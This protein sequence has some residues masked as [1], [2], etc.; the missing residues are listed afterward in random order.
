MNKLAEKPLDGRKLFRFSQSLWIGA[1]GLIFFGGGP[2]YSQE[3]ESRSEQRYWVCPDAD[4]SECY[5][6]VERIFD[7][8]Y[9]ACWGEPDDDV[10][11]NLYADDEF[12][13]DAVGHNDCR[14]GESGRIQAAERCNSGDASACYGLSFRL[15]QTSSQDGVR[16]LERACDLGFAEACV[17]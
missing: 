11:E 14:M 13:R 12:Y 9:A 6:D 10:D 1:L 4:G 17:E 2:S 3:S 8:E 5:F 7:D 15:G 16:A